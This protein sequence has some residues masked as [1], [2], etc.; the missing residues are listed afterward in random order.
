MGTGKKI[1]NNFSADSLRS[2]TSPDLGIG[3]TPHLF[4]LLIEALRYCGKLEF[5]DSGKLKGFQIATDDSL[6]AL[7]DEINE[8]A[9]LALENDCDITWT[10]FEGQAKKADECSVFALAFE[11]HSFKPESAVSFVQINGFAAM[12]LIDDA[13]TVAKSTGISLHFVECLAEASLYLAQA[14][15]I[16]KDQYRLSAER[17]EAIRKDAEFTENQR[18][19]A[20]QNAEKR[21]AKDPKRSEKD[22]I[23]DCWKLWQEKPQ[24]YK[25]KA[26]FARA[27]LDK[28]EH[29]VSQKKIEDWC[30]EWESASKNGTL[31]AE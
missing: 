13:I 22:F 18:K 19:K 25:S 15:S 12:R 9:N 8:L 14:A 24:Q 31:Q 5:D 6:K 17:T 29:I 16:Q 4:L 3:N 2:S 1:F 30:R 23:F 10:G 28:C 7:N 11:G 27:M 26:A 21:H 20:A